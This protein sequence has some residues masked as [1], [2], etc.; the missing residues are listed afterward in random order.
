MTNRATTGVMGNQAIRTIN[1]P[2][3]ESTHQP[4]SGALADL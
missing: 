3:V 2:P 4:T 1:S